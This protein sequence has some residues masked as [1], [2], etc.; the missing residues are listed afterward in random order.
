MTCIFCHQIT[1]QQ[2][3]HQTE[4]FKVV[5]DI[6][7]IQTGHLLIISKDHYESLTELPTV[8]LHELIELERKVTKL[9]EEYLPIDGVTIA[10]NDKGLMDT[11]TH[12]HVH[13]IPRKKTDGFWEPLNI[14]KESWDLKPFLDRLH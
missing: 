10:G 3:I 6:D 1:D 9:L 14:A 5:F 11:G 4:R 7:P 2:I 13:L 12:F 8:A